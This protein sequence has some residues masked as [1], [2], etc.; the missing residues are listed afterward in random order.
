MENSLKKITKGAAITFLGMAIGRTLGYTTRILMARFFGADAYGLFTLAAAILGIATTISLLGIPTG[1]SRF[2]SFY[3]GKDDKKRIKGVIKS[4]TKITVPISIISGIIIYF[5]ASD[6]SIYFFNEPKLIP[7]LKLFALIIP[8][9]SMFTLIIEC[10]RGFQNMKYKA[11]IEDVFKPTLTLT[12]LI[13]LFFMGYEIFGAAIAYSVG[14]IV[15]SV[16]GLYLLAKLFPIFRSKIRGISVTKKLFLFSWPLIITTYLWMIITWTDIIMLG[17]YKTTQEVGLYSAALTLVGIIPMVE[18]TFIFIFM[19]VI[20]ELYAKGRKEDIISMHKSVIKWVFMINLSLF[21]IMI[22]LSD[23]IL[24][25]LFGQ[26][27][28][29]ASTTLVILVFGFFLST[30]ASLTG[31]GLIIIEKTKLIMVVVLIGSVINFIINLFLIP[32]FGTVGAAMATSISFIVMAI[33][34]MFFT[35]KYLGFEFFNI[36]YIKAIISGT[37]S[38]IIF[39]FLIKIIFI[40]VQLWILIIIFPMFLLIYL[41][42]FVMMKGL[43][44]ND[45]IIIKS[46]ERKMGIKIDFLKKLVKHFL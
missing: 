45:I 43:D 6:I 36:N 32:F 34:R 18:H 30:I 12:L 35:K 33:I 27:F 29:I 19:P 15:S 25:I 37:I 5:F 44:K 26:E 20:S 42:I 22:V 2:I 11:I 23:N 21:L 9:S 46:A 31:S 10:F 7:F 41:L 40:S 3:S 4:A 8:F 16:L 14:Y 17:V 1:L 24:G 28:I 13:V 38:M 39:Y